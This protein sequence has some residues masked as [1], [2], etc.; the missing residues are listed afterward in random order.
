MYSL[1]ETIDAHLF[2]DTKYE[3]FIIMLH[4]IFITNILVE[5]VYTK[6]I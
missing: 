5:E 6:I 4:I 2:Y 1:Y 3:T